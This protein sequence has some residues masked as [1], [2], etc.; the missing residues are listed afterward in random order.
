MELTTATSPTASG[1]TLSPTA[2]L[3]SHPLFR[4][5]LVMVGIAVSV[6]F[7]VAV[8]LWSQTPSYS[9]LY[10]NLGDKGAQEVLDAL[11]K[12]GVEYR[13]EA[14]SGAVMVP[15]RKLH[16]VRMKLASQGLPHGDG[17]GFELLQQD[18]GLGASQLLTQARHHRALEGELARTIATLS[19]VEGARV[20]LALPKQ[21]VF[22]R[23]R[24]PPTASVVL[25]LH[26]GRSLERSQVDA[27]VHLVASSVPELEA[28]HVTVVD[29]K[30]T[31]LNGDRQ[32]PE[33]RLTSTQFEYARQLEDHYRQ[34]IETL[35][36]PIVGVESVRAQVTADIDFTVIEQ[37][38]E[39][40]N[41]DQP[42]L[43][44]E[45]INE[46]SSRLSA[47]QGVPGALSNQPPAPGVAPEKV[48]AQPAG[49]AKGAAP[50]PPAEAASPEEPLNTSR[51]ATRNFELDKTISHTRHSPASLRRLSV[52]VVVDD[53]LAP[54]A[55]GEPPA[56]RERTPEEIE[57]I[58]GLVREAVGYNAQRGDS[59][60]VVNAA[61][62][63]VD[64]VAA[65][66]PGF[67]EEAWFWDLLR[68]V[69]GLLLALVLILGVL[70]PTL[71]RLM[72][73]VPAPA[74]AVAGA[75]GDAQAVRGEL[76]GRYDAG[77]PAALDGPREQ[78]RL[79]GPGNYQE[80]LDAAR[81]LVKEDPKRVAQLVK[82][83]VGE[84]G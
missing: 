3:T 40:F 14:G 68:Q 64:E 34:R 19:A 36:A 48:A 63:P 57:R 12:A 21:S 28:S 75:G 77:G 13:V 6:A 71:K 53:A 69:G 9:L 5:L 22:V 82:T 25:Q 61:F 43:R 15:S 10:G 80:T 27:I 73:S 65:T 46:E 51:R 58:A 49:A 38:E 42:A 37:T 44:S 7:G 81:G 54:G 79:P 66:A 16:E 60:R 50:A 29:Q 33:M 41:P 55:E 70:R 47:V 31:L 84:N 62:R 78:V 26:A 4:Q 23:K 76:N 39:R 67:W 32:S 72:A 18:T 8:V 24:V 59:V 56:R 20:H 1:R 52:A 45:Q 30:G 74:L 35:L 11:Q 17:L 83:W 2:Q